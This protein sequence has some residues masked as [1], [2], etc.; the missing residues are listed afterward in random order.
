M[1]IVQDGGSEESNV[2]S[3][4]ASDEAHDDESELAPHDDFEVEES[5]NN[6]DEESGDSEA[7]ENE[8]GENENSGVSDENDE[9]EDHKNDGNEASEEEDE[10]GNVGWADAMAKV[11]AIGKNTDK[12]ISVLSKAK[13][14]NVKKKKKVKPEGDTTGDANDSDED[15]ILEPLAVRKARKKELDSIGRTRPD[16][17]QKNAE[18][19][20]TKIATRGVVQLFNAVREQEKVF[21]NIDKDSFVDILT[22]GKEKP[23]TDLV[24]GPPASKKPKT[25]VKD[26]EDAGVDKEESSSFL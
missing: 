16:V 10:E 8:E 11:L 22:G 12:P 13:K 24:G 25:E 9:E 5:D 2:E 26:E 15:P 1:G 3:D 19:V 17:L 21:K 4:E 23:V 7:S 14:D 20:L 6:A 18:K